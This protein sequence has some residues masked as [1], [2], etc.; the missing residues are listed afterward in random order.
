MLRAIEEYRTTSNRSVYN[1][2]RNK[3]LA[4]PCYFCSPH[5]GENLKPYKKH[6]GRK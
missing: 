3:F 4:K 6:N 1:K 2:L 5:K